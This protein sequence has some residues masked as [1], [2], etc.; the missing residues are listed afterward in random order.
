MT[1]K[2]VKIGDIFLTTLKI[3][4]SAW[5]AYLIAKIGRAHV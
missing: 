5:I 3:W 4:G 1:I 2:K